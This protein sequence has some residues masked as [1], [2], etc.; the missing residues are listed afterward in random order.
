MKK[1]GRVNLDHLKNMFLS[2]TLCKFGGPMMLICLCIYVVKC[3]GF[4]RYIKHKELVM[5]TEKKKLRPL[6]K[7]LE[8]FRTKEEGF[9]M[10]LQR[11]GENVP[12]GWR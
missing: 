2:E 3:I 8:H 11:G 7:M 9:W 12:A 1:I 6:S 5:Y 4:D 10:S